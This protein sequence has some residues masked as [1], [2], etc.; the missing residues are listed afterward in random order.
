MRFHLSKFTATPVVKIPAR[1]RDFSQKLLAFARSIKAGFAKRSRSPPPKFKRNSSYEDLYT[2]Y[3][4]DPFDGGH[5]S[6]LT[7]GKSMEYTYPITFS[8]SSPPLSEG[9]S[10]SFIKASDILIG[11]KS[12]CNVSERVNSAPQENVKV[13]TETHVTL[14]Q[15]ERTPSHNETGSTYY[16]DSLQAVEDE[17]AKEEQEE[18]RAKVLLREDMASRWFKR[19]VMDEESYMKISKLHEVVTLPNLRKYSTVD[20]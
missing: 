20:G 5:T 10:S 18:A 3:L 8:G 12:G 19:R 16:T 11:S 9:P 7:F 13:N 14:L 6:D 2:A 17:G 15:V 4:L 1:T